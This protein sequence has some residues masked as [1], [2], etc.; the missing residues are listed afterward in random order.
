[1]VKSPAIIRPMPEQDEAIKTLA[2]LS[3]RYTH[4]IG[5]PEGNSPFALLNLGAGQA[6]KPDRREGVPRGVFEMLWHS[7]WIEVELQASDL[8]KR[9]YRISPRGRAQLERLQSA[10]GDG[11]GI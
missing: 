6:E 9:L 2:A 11:A 3:E 7:G 8:S 10:A 4:L 5:T 1:M